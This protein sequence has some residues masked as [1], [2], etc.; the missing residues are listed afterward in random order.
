MKTQR[1]TKQAWIW[2]AVLLT[3][4]IIISYFAYSPKVQYY[5]DYVT[6]SPSPT[7]LKAIY[8]YLDKETDVSKWTHTPDLLSKSRNKK[9]LVMA[10]P[11]FLPEKKEMKA[12]V[13]FMEAGNTILL[14]KENPDKMFDLKADTVK[15]GETSER[16]Y[17][18]NSKMFFADV[19]SSKRLVPQKGDIV[20]FHDN[21]GVISLKRPI[22]KGQLIASVAPEWMANGTI[23][24]DDHLPLILALLKEGKTESILF[25]EYMHGEQNAPTMLTVYPQWFLLMVLQGLLLV[26]LWLWYNGKRFGPIFIPREETVRFSD[27]GLRAM[28]AW[29]LRG[30]RYHDSLLI[31]SDYVKLL[32]QERWGI[33]YGTEWQNVSGFLER[34]GLKMPQKEIRA[35][36][37]GL[38]TVLGK[39]K[40]TKQEFLLWSR[41]LDRLRKEVDEG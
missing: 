37:D 8:T 16:V 15:K 28:A 25:D 18:R 21:N 23:L 33:P 22:G 20:L 41:K 2:F 12:Y 30:K 1:S 29:Y 38:I 6:S 39:E 31:Q 17:D 5:P 32:L 40:L 4:F 19:H 27:E 34:K 9:L 13:D 14:L 3:L 36:L 11:S 35:F 24:K 26:I 7:G 10:E